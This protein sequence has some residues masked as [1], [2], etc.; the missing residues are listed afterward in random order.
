MNPV[1]LRQSLSWSGRVIHPVRRWKSFQ[2]NVGIT[3]KRM[4]T[5][6]GP[7][8]CRRRISEAHAIGTG[9]GAYGRSFLS[10]R[11]LSRSRA[12]VGFPTT[13]LHLPVPKKKRD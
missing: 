5:T 4:E 9:D 8:P 1:R 2:F 7:V 10:L 6:F 13:V 3:R 11:Q 12:S